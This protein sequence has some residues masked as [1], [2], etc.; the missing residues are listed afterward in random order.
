MVPVQIQQDKWF[1]SEHCT[2]WR[3]LKAHGQTE[4]RK[5]SACAA[6]HLPDPI[7]G[8]RGWIFFFEHRAILF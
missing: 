1:Y 2:P 6:C 8:D 7:S 5:A 3:L 4:T